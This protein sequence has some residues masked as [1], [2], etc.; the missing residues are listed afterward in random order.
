[1]VIFANFFV[2]KNIPRYNTTSMFILKAI[3]KLI[4]SLWK[5]FLLIGVITLCMIFGVVA[6]YFNIS[7][8][9]IDKLLTIT[10]P[11]SSKIFAL[12]GSLLYEFYGEVR[13]TPVPLSDISPYLKQAVISIEDKRFYEHGGVSAQDIAR[14]IIK[15]KD[16]GAVEQGAS[17]ITQQYVKNAWLTNERSFHRKILEA[18]LAWQLERKYSKDQILEGY[19]NAVPFGR[20]AYGAESASDIFFGKHA[21]ELSLAEAAYLASLTQAPSLYN[22]F[23]PNRTLLDERKDTV[24]DKM[25]E[26]NYISTTQAKEAKEE[27]VNFQI[28]KTV[29]R[30]PQ[31][32]F[33]VEDYINRKYGP[34]A[35]RTE[36]L[37]IYTSLDPKIQ[38]MAEQ[39]IQNAFPRLT[40]SYNAHN[41]S[42]VAVDTK[43]GLLLAMV[44]S[45]DFY[46]DPEPKNCTPGKNCL[47]DPQVNAATSL[48]Q[49]GSSFKPYVYVT[50]FGQEFAYSPASAII[51]APLTIGNYAPKNYTGSYFGRIPIRRALAGSL[52]IPAVK[53]LQ[54]IG[55]DSVLKTIRDLGITAPFQNCGPA[56][57]LGSCEVSLVEHTFAYSVLA[58]QGLKNGNTAIVK[59]TDKNGETLDAYKPKGEQ[60]IHAH[61]AYELITIMTDNDARSF[62][63]GKNSPLAFKKQQVA[64]KTGTTDDWKD[65][66]TMG[67]T[68]NVAVGVWV[69]NN[70]GTLL[71]NG[72]DAIVSA[73]PLWRSFMDKILPL[74]PADNFVRP[75]SIVEL[76]PSQI[77]AQARKDYIFL[78]ATDVFA[79]YSQ[80]KKWLKSL[81][82]NI[83]DEPQYIPG[84]L[85]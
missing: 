40:R 45:K 53:M 74:Y 83:E 51:D 43:T 73:A 58:N 8:K 50:A 9:Y 48:R 7:S 30:Y 64:A 56:M 60:V 57:A 35:L 47:F 1:M 6:F 37:Q 25:V 16:A 28:K 27:I 85:R 23:G 22:P 32:V 77:P 3:A 71:R 29:I 55:G 12:D 61:A 24:L 15:N 34:D 14:A 11:A 68:P 65:A 81:K 36:G 41:A 19:L 21:K 44:G 75:A 33:W 70:N 46:A 38:D 18:M 17:T 42:L 5:G 76:K 59:I 4:S 52:N 69:G 67:F 49:P 78:H 26:Q 66:W 63:F 39:T 20:N 54:Q 62:I 82:P 13:R 2:W 80:P 31:F 84:L 72:A 10:P 79:D